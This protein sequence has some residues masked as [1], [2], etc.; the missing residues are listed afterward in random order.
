M[1][2]QSTFM[3]TAPVEAGQLEHLRVIL[4]SMDRHGGM[5]DPGNPLVPFGQFDRLH[6]ARFFIAE[7]V[8]GDDI[9][10]YGV[11]PSEWP[12]TLVFLG[13]C[14]GPT[15]SFLA[16]LV[17]RAG[18]GLRKIFSYCVGFSED[19]SDLLDWMKKHNIKPAANYINW[20]GRTVVQAREEADLHKGLAGH[21]KEIIDEVGIEDTRQ[22]R[23]NLLSFMEFEQQQGRL[24]LTPR[25]RT[26]PG[27]AV[28]NFLHLVGVPLG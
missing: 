8:T 2:P 24:L 26:P 3:V 28:R 16:E 27:W 22:L 19:A 21:L 5:A 14:D 1:M 12:P 4:R 6:V 15:D 9:A 10:V 23:Q 11:T 25:P 20:I 18:P 13:D 7:A 17:A